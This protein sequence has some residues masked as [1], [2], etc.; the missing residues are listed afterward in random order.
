MPSIASLA[1]RESV[2]FECCIPTVAVGNIPGIG[3]GN[4]DGMYWYMVA[5]M[6]ELTAFRSKSSPANQEGHCESKPKSQRSMFGDV[7]IPL[8]S[9]ELLDSDRAFDKVL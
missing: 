3:C 5:A 2:T 9:P 8:I 6:D 7:C 1:S 4:G